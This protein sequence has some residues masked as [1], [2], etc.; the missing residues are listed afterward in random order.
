MIDNT[1]ADLGWAPRVAMHDA[2]E[3]IFE[4]YRGQVAQARELLD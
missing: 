2:L 4:A 3:R 1:M